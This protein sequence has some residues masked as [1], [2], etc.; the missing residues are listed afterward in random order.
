MA[1]R[2]VSAMIPRRG[3]SA[4]GTRQRIGRRASQA[5]EQAGSVV[6]CKLGNCVT[7][8]RCISQERWHLW[9]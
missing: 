2:A 3:M 1:T 8:R 5:S 4:Q 6:R 7:G 9:Q